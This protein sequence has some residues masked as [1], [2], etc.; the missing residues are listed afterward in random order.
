[1]LRCSG[2]LCFASPAAADDGASCPTPSFLLVC[3]FRCC[4]LLLKVFPTRV[5]LQPPPAG[6]AALRH[7]QRMQRDAAEEAEEENYRAASSVAAS[8]GVRIPP[9][10]S[11]I[12]GGGGGSG[13]A[14]DGGKTLSRQD[15]GK[16]LSW[17]VTIE[18]LQAKQRQLEGE[19]EQQEHEEQNAAVE[20]VLAAAE[21]AGDELSIRYGGTGLRHRRKPGNGGAGGKETADGKQR[22][23]QSAATP[24]AAPALAASLWSSFHPLQLAVSAAALPWRTLHAAGGA[25]GS[26]TRWA[27]T[28]LPLVGS[29]F[30][31][32]E[33]LLS[34]AE[35]DAELDALEQEMQQLGEL[36]GLE[37]PAGSSRSGKGED[38][39]E[40]STGQGRGGGGGGSGS[41]TLRL[42]EASLRYGLGMLARS[43]GSPRQLFEPSNSYERQLL[44]EVRCEGWCDAR[45]TAWQR[46]CLCRACMAAGC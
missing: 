1:M 9:K 23:P 15:W 45:H 18:T 8:S 13:S 12:Y 27:L 38:E 10:A 17:A 39:E 33:E 21:E 28:H 7:Q 36:A 4:R 32:I 29:Y 22:R 14:A 43:S 31:G 24:S 20:E 35:L 25:A 30:G 46:I 6:P 19:R 11:D 44:A 3:L 2:C 42:C 40:W 16:V 34:L 41:G 5:R 26:A 37:Q